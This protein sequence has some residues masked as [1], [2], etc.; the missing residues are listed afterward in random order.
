MSTVVFD[1][2]EVAEWY[3]NQHLKVDVGLVS[4][5]YL[6]GNCDTREIRLV[7]VNEL[8]GDRTDESLQ[9]IDFGV[10]MGTD[11]AHRLFVLDVTPEQWERLKTGDLCLPVNWTLRDS[12]T[13]NKKS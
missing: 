13:F 5:H 3:A 10:D 2:D 7:E 12:I 6:P 4:V 11:E 8:L 9:P 1:R